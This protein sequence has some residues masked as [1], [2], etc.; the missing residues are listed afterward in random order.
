MSEEKKKPA[1][2]ATEAKIT[3]PKA[4]TVPKE[5]YDQ[6]LEQVMKM[7]ETLNGMQGAKQKEAKMDE[8]TIY[9]RVPIVSY[10]MGKKRLPVNKSKEALLNGYKQV[11]YLSAKEVD[12]ILS[13]DN[14]RKRFDEGLLGFQDEVYYDYFGVTCEYPLHDENIIELLKLDDA[15]MKSKLDEITGNMKKESVLHHLV[16]RIAWLVKN[17]KLQGIPASKIS[18]LDK[19]F[20]GGL[21]SKWNMNLTKAQSYLDFMDTK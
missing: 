11:T 3:K 16:Y 14:I 13:K 4:E 21:P 7:Q 12:D 1:T 20:F 5:S 6:L 15:E 19:I 18:F 17:D 8:I 2:K 9:T 10:M